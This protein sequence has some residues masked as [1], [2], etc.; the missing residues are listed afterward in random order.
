MA[1]LVW[2]GLNTYWRVLNWPAMVTI[3]KIG[4]H[5]NWES[6]GGVAPGA[7]F[8][9]EEATHDPFQTWVRKSVS[10]VNGSPQRSGFKMICA[11]TTRAHH[12]TAAV[13]TGQAKEESK[14]ALQFW[15]P[16]C[17]RRPMLQPGSA[18]SSKLSPQWAQVV[19]HGETCDTGC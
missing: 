10:T 13:S 2:V 12:E 17:S 3:A 19:Y 15:G 14:T 11:S 16:G 9:A 8:L 4:S 5:T 6:L 7:R 1:K 18:E